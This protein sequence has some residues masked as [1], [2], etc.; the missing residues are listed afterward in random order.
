MEPVR[1]TVLLSTAY[2][3]P[4]EYFYYL[5]KARKVY[6][7]QF[8]T[9]PKQTYRNRCEIYSEKGKML[10]SIPVTKP[11]GNHTKTK[12]VIIFNGQRWF[13]NHWRAIEAAYL[14]SPFFLYYRDELE[15]FFTGRHENLLRF[16]LSFLGTVCKMIGIEPSVELTHG[17]V[18]SPAGS[19]DLRFAIS[20]KKPPTLKH[21]PAY[22]QVF[23][24]RHGFVPNLSII[25]LLFNLGPDTV[26]YL[27]TLGN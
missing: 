18:K 7:E 10:L 3:P 4:V 9:Y 13:L 27:E 11:E 19:T 21:F 1:N 6:I 22:I 20:P 16:N 2:L 12:D 14:G 25:D 24:E 26:D 5:L 15:T 17:F 8:E 23:S